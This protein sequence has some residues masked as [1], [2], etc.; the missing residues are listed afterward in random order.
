LLSHHPKPRQSRWPGQAPAL[1]GAIHSD[2]NARFE[3]KVE[4]KASAKAG[5][6]LIGERWPLCGM[7][8]T[9]ELVV[10]LCTHIGMIMEDASVVAL[11]IG[12]MSSSEKSIALGKL[13]QATATA[14]RLM[15]A[16]H[17]VRH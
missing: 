17:A 4:W 7:D 11:T 13:G 8:D 15:Q 1:P 9:E 6:G 10:L 12:G 5:Y 2:T 16:V 3:G 14:E